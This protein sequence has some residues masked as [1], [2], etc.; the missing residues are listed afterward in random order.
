MG[1]RAGERFVP[2]VPGVHLGCDQSRGA[3]EFSCLDGG[4][5]GRLLIC[6]WH[7]LQAILPGREALHRLLFGYRG[8]E[9]CWLAGWRLPEPVW[10]VQVYFPSRSQAGPAGARAELASLGVAFQAAALDQGKRGARS[11]RGPQVRGAPRRGSRV[12][13]L[14]LKAPSSARSLQR[15]FRELGG[16]L[17]IPQPGVFDL[18]AP[19]PR[20]GAYTKRNVLVEALLLL[21]ESF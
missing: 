8:R 14:L 9:A 15:G 7:H 17:H 1:G 6:A 5:A 2:A 3:Y 10:H 12:H 4:G 11:S 16:G 21:A 20:P 13:P 18:G 19:L